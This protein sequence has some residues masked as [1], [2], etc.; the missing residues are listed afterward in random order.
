MD[1]HFFSRTLRRHGLFLFSLRDAE[2]LL[3]RQEKS[4]LTLQF[5]QWSKKG[6]IRRLKRGLYELSY[7]EPAPLSDLYVANRLYEPSYVSLETALSHYQ[8]LP[9]TAAQVTSVTPKPTRRLRNIHGLFT[10]FTVRP[11][12]FT[13]Y[14][15]LRLQGQPVRMAEPEKAVTDRLYSGMRRGEAFRPKEERWDTAKVKKLDRKK[16]LSY[17]ALFGASRSRLEELIYALLR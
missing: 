4:L 9:E 17:A 1:I 13:G 5:H 8:I 7:P 15:V 3:P 11:S 12:A 10:Y 6:W 16:L 14:S 2:I